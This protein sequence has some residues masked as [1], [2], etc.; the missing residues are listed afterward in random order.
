M[1]RWRLTPRRPVQEEPRPRA[2]PAWKVLS[3]L[4]ILVL[5]GAKYGVVRGWG[6]SEA[7][8]ALVMAA[9]LVAVAV[10][11]LW[12]S[13]KPPDSNSKGQDM[14]KRQYKGAARGRG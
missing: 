5:Y 10:I 11:L 3:V 9:G 1:T 7:L 13:T 8:H 4:A 2:W 12:P 14:P 6:R